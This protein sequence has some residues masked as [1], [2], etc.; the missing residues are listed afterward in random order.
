MRGTIA[1]AALVALMAA[2][3]T[4]CVGGSKETSERDKARLKAYVLDKA[5]ANIPHTLNVNFEN[6]V[7]LLGYKVEPEGV[8]KPGGQVKLT[9]YW[10][11]D[12]KLDDGWNLFTHVLD[13]SGERVLNID[14]VGPLREFR[15]T[16]QVLWPTAWEPGKY[17]LD[18]QSFT[19]P[20]NV[21]TD[22]IQ[23]V[24]GIWRDNDRLK[25]LSGPHDRE[26]RAIVAT[27]S[28]SVS[29]NPAAANASTRVPMLRAD[30]LPKEQKIK[31]DGKLD[32][33][34]WRT[35][36][37][38]GPFLDVRTGRPNSAF[39]VNGSVKVLWNS[40][41][42]YLGFDV[43]DPDVVGG[44]DAKQKDPHLWTKDT[45]EVM[46]D[47]DGDGDN[48][49]YYEIQVNPQNLV[50][51]SRFEDYNLPKKEP[52]GPFGHQEWSSQLKSAVTVNG[53]LDN[54]A[55]KDQGYVAEVMIPWKAFDKAKK[56]PPEIGDTWR[57][58]F[59]AMEANSGVA[60]SPIL[61]QGNFHKASRFG[62]IQFAEK[63]WLPPMPT[64][65][66]PSA[67][68]APGQAPLGT[69]PAAG[70]RERQ[71]QPRRLPVLKVPK[72]PQ[73]K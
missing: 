34:A 44:F 21:R 48:K 68:A 63:G 55:D 51:D 5:P 1:T 3:F 60:W 32:E 6:K 31:I 38:A 15:E 40:D 11:T 30:K 53:T 37:T 67:S 42:L 14:N 61:G 64:P 9:M 46:V 43:K 72:P 35:A 24:T 23:V 4:G 52:D 28:T 69:A 57:I 8:L 2:S 62:R 73:V 7:T 18:E 22:K 20:T 54:S 56:A 45:V 27:L 58:N 70:I 71:I 66:F 26:N 29:H 65:A 49:D 10:R 13:G 47:P 33:E 39:P 59:Y 17:Y 50:F 16:H 25:P 19:V 41:A 36:P 12:K